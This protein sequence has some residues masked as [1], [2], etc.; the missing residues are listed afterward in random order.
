MQDNCRGGEEYDDDPLPCVVYSAYFA[1]PNQGELDSPVNNISK[2]PM[3]FIAGI[4]L[5]LSSSCG[6]VALIMETLA[7]S[8]NRTD[9]VSRTIAASIAPAIPVWMSTAKRRTSVEIVTDLVTQPV[10]MIRCH[11]E[12]SSPANQT[13]EMNPETARTM[14]RVNKRRLSA[15]P[16]SRRA[17]DPCL[18]LSGG[19]QSD[20]VIITVVE[21][22]LCQKSADNDD[23]TF[24]LP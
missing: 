12:L 18:L 17:S 13:Y 8:C 1:W 23:K 10:I 15:C 5:N 16:P 24:H 19:V 20:P 9:A 11:T 3:P 21:A 7:A 14:A 6:L 2:I 4:K 22:I